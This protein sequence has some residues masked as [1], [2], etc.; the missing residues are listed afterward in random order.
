MVYIGVDLG[1]TN[2]AVGIVDEHSNILLK[3]SVPTEAGRGNTAVIRD[4]CALAEQLLTQLGLTVADVAA[5]GIASPGSILPEEGV[6]ERSDNLH[7]FRFPIVEVFRSFLPIE[8]IYLENDANA[9]AWAEAIAGAAK[10]TDNSVMI[11]LGTGLGG[12]I[13][14]NKKIYY[15]QNGA[16]GELGHV[17]IEHKGR[18]CPCGRRGCWEAYSSAT[19]LIA[20][21]EEKLRECAALKQKTLMTDH[22]KEGRISGRTAFNAAKAGDPYGLSVVETYKDYLATGIINLIN[23]FQPEVLSIGGGICHEGDYLL[24][25]DL[26]ERI[27]REQYTR[28][29][30]KKT[31]IK[32]AE[33]GNDAGIIGSAGLAFL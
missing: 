21:T 1:G 13:I 7:F 24:S 19:G 25:K 27:D 29:A 18:L 16:A 14:L 8:K 3:G 4:M 5:A 10:G 9:A 2:I 6:V 28:D 20:M 11:T 15:G 30:E 26:L 31:K 22:L 33:L 12:G 32:I 17:V 23:T